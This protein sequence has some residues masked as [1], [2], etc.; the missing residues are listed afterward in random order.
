MA[1]GMERDHML[2]LLGYVREKER[3]WERAT[4]FSLPTCGA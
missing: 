1:G 3:A 4:P 2:E